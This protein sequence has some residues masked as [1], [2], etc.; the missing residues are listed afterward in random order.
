VH[1]DSHPELEIIARAY[2]VVPAAAARDQVLVQCPHPQIE[3]EEPDETQHDAEKDGSQCHLFGWVPDNPDHR[4]DDGTT[5]H[6][7]RELST[8]YHD[9]KSL[10]VQWLIAAVHTSAMSR[11]RTLTLQWSLPARGADAD[12]LALGVVV[13]TKGLGAALSSGAPIIVEILGELAD[14]LRPAVCTVD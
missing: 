10:C 11:K 14:L 6:H 12:G 13:S 3:K 7:D 8:S 1:Q 2:A 9:Q 4:C 5:H